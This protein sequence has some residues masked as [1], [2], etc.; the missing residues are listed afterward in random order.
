MEINEILN[1]EWMP[2]LGCTE[3]AAIAYA[4]A[5]AS[6]LLDTTPKSIRL[7]VDARTYKNCFSVG[8]PRTDG[9]TGIL[10][11]VAIGSYLPSDAINDKL[12]CF[13]HTN[14]KV[15]D[16]AEILIKGN[17][18][19]VE[20]KQTT[21]LLID[22]VVVGEKGW[23]RSVIKTNHTNLIKRERDGRPCPLPGEDEHPPAS[24][25]PYDLLSEKKG[26]H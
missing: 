12:Q 17:R 22:C 19:S 9:K 21:D 20:V 25:L 16:N 15:I 14:E 6:E 1:I 26:I 3:P 4:A 5:A 13:Q 8:I 7:T 10:W 23:A 18:I 11:A 2:T 24:L